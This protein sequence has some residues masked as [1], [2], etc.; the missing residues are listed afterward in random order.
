LPDNRYLQLGVRGPLPRDFFALLR[1]GLETTLR[2]YPGLRMQRMIP[3]PDRMKWHCQETCEFDFD[4]LEKRRE[5][6]PNKK[7]VECRAGYPDIPLTNL[8][9]AIAPTDVEGIDEWGVKITN[10]VYEQRTFLK[11]L[12]IQ[13]NP[14]HECPNVF[15][16]R[17]SNERDW[18]GRLFGTTVILQ[19]YCQEPGEWHPALED[20]RYEIKEPSEWYMQMSFYVRP[21]WDILKSTLPVVSPR[22]ARMIPGIDSIIQTDLKSMAD[23]MKSFSELTIGKDLPSQESGSEQRVIVLDAF[24][25]RLM[26]AFLDECDP[27]HVWGGLIKKR[28]PEGHY[29]WLCRAH[30]KQYEK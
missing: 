14:E 20:G 24:A 17:P 11:G 25:M 3:C 2:R 18:V 7:A 27:R 10:L 23:L 9:Y 28:T 19:L 22:L 12:M 1:D 21:L 4:L 13:E 16:L 5:R 29:L 15:I 8:L 30:A 26:R 6:A